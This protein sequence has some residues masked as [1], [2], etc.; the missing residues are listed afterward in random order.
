[1]DDQNGSR[2]RAGFYRSPMLPSFVE[3]ASTEFSGAVIG[4]L[5]AAIAHLQ[6]ELAP[7]QAAWLT[8][9]A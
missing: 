6:K 7:V 5:K 9:A 8:E 2:G 4:F 1:M 3:R